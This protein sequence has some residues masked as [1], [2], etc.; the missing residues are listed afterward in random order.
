MA[1]FLNQESAFS[2]E[3]ISSAILGKL[4]KVAYYYLEEPV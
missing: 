1:Q 4:K 3:E 2:P